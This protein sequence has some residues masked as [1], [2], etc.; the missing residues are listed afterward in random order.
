[1]LV[2]Y[3]IGSHTRSQESKSRGGIGIGSA[4]GS[5]AVGL[6]LSFP[7]GKDKVVK[8]AQ[9]IVDFLDPET[10][11]LQWRGTNLIGITDES[12]EAITTM[13][14]EAVM[15]ILERYPPES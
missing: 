11:K 4:G 5:T 1:M 2:R 10:R 14:N 6:S 3:Y 12:P 9:I 13:V 8:R 15:A 7:L